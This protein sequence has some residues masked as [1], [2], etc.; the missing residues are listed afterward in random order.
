MVIERA[1]LLEAAGADGIEAGVADQLLGDLA[2]IFVRGVE[3]AGRTRWS[4]IS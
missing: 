2:S 3:L 4:S 1:S